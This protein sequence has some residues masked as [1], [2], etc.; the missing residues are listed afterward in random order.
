MKKLNLVWFQLI[1]CNGN[2]HSF[3][4]NNDFFSIIK[5]FNLI[6]YP[7]LETQY[8]YDELLTK[9]LNCDILII[10]GAYKNGFEKFGYKI[11]EILLNYANKAKYIIT[12][13]TCATYGGIFKEND[14]NNISGFIFDK[15]QKTKRFDKF[16]NRVISI[17][18]CPIH[19]KWLGFVLQMI[20]Q[21][22]KIILDEFK[23][24]KE[25]FAYTVHNGCI[26]NE[27]FEWKVD[28]KGF[29]H[30][31]GCMFYEQGCQGPYTHGS[32]NKILWNEISSKTITG[33]PCFGCTEPTFPKKRLFFTK[34]SMGIPKEVP[35]G[36]SKRAYLTLTGVAKSFKIKRLE[37][38]LIK[39]DS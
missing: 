36:V 11:D 24:P 8:S 32:C 4:N 34:T 22:K 19:P 38:K 29:G 33:T 9:N 37:S 26:R 35:L 13:G 12:A 23:R 6:Y 27:Y 18:G 10:E 28:T 7:L 14:P 31:E 30:K 15:E 25:L 20:S 39:D 17:P 3:F 21:N 1:T 16:K 5:K 2:S